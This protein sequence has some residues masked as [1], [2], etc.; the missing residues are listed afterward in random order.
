[1]CMGHDRS[2]WC[3]WKKS[4]GIKRTKYTKMYG[5]SFCCLSLLEQSPTSQTTF[6]F[7][8][9]YVK[10]TFTSSWQ[11]YCSVYSVTVVSQMHLLLLCKGDAW[12]NTL[13]W[14][15]HR[16]LLT[17]LLYSRPDT[18]LIK[19]SLSS[20]SCNTQK[21]TPAGLLRMGGK[22]SLTC[23]N[24]QVT[25][26]RTFKNLQVCCISCAWITEHDG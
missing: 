6:L 22:C 26:S 25:L 16:S 23:S 13:R 20:Q 17:L 12:T 15:S 8:M 18:L 4:C 7:H 9:A 3:I 19:A 14:L 1:M 2:D 24:I 5:K 11:Y 21:Y 10:G